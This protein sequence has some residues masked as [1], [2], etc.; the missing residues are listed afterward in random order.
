MQFLAQASPKAEIRTCNDYKAINHVDKH[1]NDDYD[2]RKDMLCLYI[3]HENWR[4]IPLN[5]M[6]VHRDPGDEDSDA[7]HYHD[8]DYDYDHDYD[9]NSDDDNDNDYYHSNYHPNYH[10]NDNDDDD[11]DDDNH[12]DNH[13]H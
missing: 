10:T 2:L 3:L 6:L 8:Y 5:A 4:R 7:Y 12:D 13:D 11:D 9:D 1:E